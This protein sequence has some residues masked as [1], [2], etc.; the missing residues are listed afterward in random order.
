VISSGAVRAAR[1]AVQPGV[2]HGVVR[3]SS[4]SS[5]ADRA[6]GR[7]GRL[8]RGADR[9]LAAAGVAN[10]DE[11]VLAGDDRARRVVVDA[12]PRAAHFD[13]A[14]ARIDEEALVLAA[15]RHDDVDA[16]VDRE[17]DDVGVEPAQ[18]E[19]R[20]RSER[21]RAGLAELRVEPARA[22]GR[23]HGAR[24]ERVCERLIGREPV[25]EHV[26]GEP[27]D[28]GG[29]RRGLRCGRRSCMRDDRRDGRGVI[30]VCAQHDD[31]DGRGRDH[32]AAD[33]HRQAKV[34]LLDLF[35]PLGRHRPVHPRA[36]RI[37]AEVGRLHRTQR[38]KRRRRALHAI[39]CA[40]AALARVGVAIDR[41][42]LGVGEPA[43]ERVGPQVWRDVPHDSSA[44]AG[45][46]GSPARIL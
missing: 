13:D 39:A 6:A 1:S 32:A 5:S 7:D 44:S 27:A 26:A 28:A 30:A 24:A 22:A 31:R 21:E 2:A 14:I 38:R 33:Q 37:P 8:A 46:G 19:L 16:A 29:E 4:P 11:A 41:G 25:D 35:V 34:A 43:G 45:G 20:A 17:L 10:G 15:R 23:D 12:E 42:D 40:A 9:D 3:V 36:D 18:L